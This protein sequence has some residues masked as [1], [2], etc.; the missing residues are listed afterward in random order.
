MT[1]L[2]DPVGE[3]THAI[4]S[5][6]PTRAQILA[7]EQEIAAL[8][9]AVTELPT[10]H[11]FAPGLYAREVKIPA[12][13]VLTGKTHRYAQL[14]VLAEGDITVWIDG[15]MKRIQAPHTFV[16]EA[17]TKRVGFA[18][19]DV[20]W[21]TFHATQETDLDKI[22]AEVIAPPE[23]ALESGREMEALT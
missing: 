22:E 13:F 2:V 5:P 11:H 14:N 18:H 19:T 9:H 15:G 6:A 23:F 20:T 17:G 16:S 21:I 4:G 1:D 7:F 12:G 10:T 3:L 8:P